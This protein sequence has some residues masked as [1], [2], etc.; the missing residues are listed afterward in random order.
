MNF[1]AHDPADDADDV[2]PAELPVEPDPVVAQAQRAHLRR[3]L[4]C[5]VVV[6]LTLPLAG[7]GGPWSWLLLPILVVAALALR[8]AVRLRRS[9]RTHG[10]ARGR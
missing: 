10:A 8:E 9:V 4:V 6:V 3:I 2:N 7:L 5:F 1:R